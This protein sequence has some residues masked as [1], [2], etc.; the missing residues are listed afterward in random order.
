MKEE[1]QALVAQ[2]R[3]EEALKLFATVNQDAIL[4]QARFASAKKQNSMG[5]IEFSEWSRIQNQI[6]FALLDLVGSGTK[7]AATPAPVTTITSSQP[8]I[9]TIEPA[10]TAKKV[11]ISYNHKDKNMSLAVKNYLI[12]NGCDV[13]ID[14]DDMQAGESIQSFIQE[15][16]KENHYILSLVSEN[17]LQSGWV[18][19][20][21]T[22]AFFSEWLAD[23]QFIPVAL[24]SKFHDMDF[25]IEILENLDTKIKENLKKIKKINN[26]GADSRP[27]QDENN[28]LFDLKSNIGIIIQ[29]LKSI[30]TVDISAANFEDGMVKVLKRINN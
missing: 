5:L 17:S 10:K 8:S 26:L 14:V 21:S 29:K 30:L 20:E 15:K 2:G 28:R 3:T 12:E 6:N 22:A 7:I 24:D 1:I 18:G 23:K 19:K 16:I 11:F 13:T 25:Y 4:L 27:V 9:T